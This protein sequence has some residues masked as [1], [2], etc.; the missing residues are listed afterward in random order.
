MSIQNDYKYYAFIS[1]SRKNSPAANYLQKSLERSRIPT[2]KIHESFLPDDGKHIKPVFLDKR[3]L[4]VSEKDFSENIQYAIENS[5]YLL[6]LCSPESVQSEWV[7]KE[8]S[9]FLKT[10]NNAINAIVPIILSGRPGS[11]GED[12]CLPEELRHADITSRNLPNMMAEKDETEKQGW[13]NGLVQA[14]S[15]MLRVDRESIKATIDA[16]KMRIQRNY[17]I[18]SL[19]AL[20]ISSILTAWALFAERKAKNNADLA[21]RNEVKANLNAETAKKNEMRAVAGEKKAQENEAEAKRQAGIAQKNEARAIAGEK[22]ALENEAE[23]KRQAD[24]AKKSLEFL[25]NV[26]LSSDP[27]KSGNKDIKV[28]DAIN[29]KISEIH[30]IKEWQLKASVAMTV[31]VIFNNLGKHKEALNL[32]KISVSL[33]EKH[34]PGTEELAASYNIIGLLYSSQ[35]NYAAAFENHQKALTIWKKNLPENHPYIAASYNNIGL[36][37]SNQ[38]NYAAALDYQQKA[39]AIRKKTLPENHPDIA[40]SYHNIGLLYSNQR[41]YTAALNYH[42]KALAIR[43]KTLPEN[44]PDIAQNYNNIGVVYFDQKKCAAALDYYQKA[45]AI[46]KKILPENHPDI[47]RSYNNIGVVYDR[48][49]NYTEALDY[50]RKALAI[51]K[52]TLP[53]NHPDIAQSYSNIGM[54]YRGQRNYTEALDYLQKAL[55]IRKKTLPENHPFIASSYNN[56]GITYF[57]TGKYKIAYDHIKKA[58]EMARLK[59]GEKH[60]STKRYLKNL[61][62]AEQKLKESKQK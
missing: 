7:R 61:K 24:V 32:L 49:R 14:M 36:L 53:E 35:G 27:T 39:L 3:D 54:V 25:Q 51:R 55:A 23:A 29:A 47:A 62:I 16:E 30:R 50:F 9:Y 12:E 28:I 45:L 59:R 48:H 26:F 33:Y 37:Y 11:G 44:H 60:P 22:K 43:K 38:G 10:H 5:R 52:K 58:Y 42:Q 20:L 18:I 40:K 8:I 21:Q 41:N 15:Y 6:V 2:K 34:A 17:T 31:G 19:T 4:E 13:E 57:S 56:I 1:Y 46:Y